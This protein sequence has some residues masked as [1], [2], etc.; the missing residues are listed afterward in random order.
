MGLKMAELFPE[1]SRQKPFTKEKAK[2]RGRAFENA[3]EAIDALE[4]KHGKR[5]KA[6]TYHNADSEPVG[7]VLRWDTASGKVIRP[8]ARHSDG[9][10]IG[11]MPGPRP[12]YR[13]PELLPAALAL[14]G[15]GEKVVEAA[16]FLGF[17]ATTSSGGCEAAAKTDWQPLAGKEVWVLNDNDAAGRKFAETAAS[18]LSKLAPAPLIRVL[19]LAKHA[20]ALPVGGDLADVLSDPAF[21][22]LPLGDAA[23]LSD[24]KAF[25]ERMAQEVE[26]WRAPAGDTG[27]DEPARPRPEIVIG[28]DEFRVNAEAVEALAQDKDLFQRAGMLVYVVNAQTAD[29]SAVLRRPDPTLVIRN[30]PLPLLRERLTQCARWLKWR[31]SGNNAELV[32]AHPPEWSVSG[33]GARCDWPSVRRLEAVVPHPVLLPN[34]SILKTNGYD[35]VSRLLVCLPQDLRISVPE[36][37]SMAEVALAVRILRDVVVDF[38]FESPVH[39]GAFFAA[40]LTPLA[41]FAFTG[42]APL[43]LFD[44][45]IRAAGKGLLADVIALIVTGRRFPIMSYTSEREELRKR[46]TTLAVGGDRMVLLDNLNGPIG[47]DILD[48]ALTADRWKDRVLGGNSVFDGPLHVCWYA[49]GNNVQLLADTARRVCHCRM[50]SQEEHPELREAFRH[51]ELR[52]HVQQERGKLLSAALTILRAWAT[53]GK[54][55]HGLKPWGSFEGW[56]NVVREAVVFAGLPDPGEARQALQSAADRDAVAMLALIDALEQ[57]DPDRRGLTASEI[58]EAIRKPSDPPAGWL[59]D[60]RSSVEELCG[61]LDSR[62]LGYKFRHFAR[63][64]FNGRMIDRTT[65]VSSANS[66]RWVVCRIVHGGK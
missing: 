36:F 39:V 64:N 17:T 19:D 61:R 50:E 5:S 62:S 29:E 56:S 7:I 22:G 54:P 18:I 35:P 27:K 57:M 34:G 53:S 33:I 4:R 9:W 14:V 21:C 13:L 41:W 42:P 1:Q 30:V 47:N 32:P 49:T 66:V 51:P 43:F 8:V 55:K 15:E 58:V 48:A 26:P 63:R 20:S 2:A 25:I 23:E 6:W 52:Q 3:D 10:H 65:S 11:A 16:R 40:L 24:V 45:N 31:G 46:I 60:L 28:T 38:P 44:A 59:S 12:L 37:P